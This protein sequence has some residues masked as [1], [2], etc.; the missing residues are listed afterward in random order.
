MNFGRLVGGVEW[1]QLAQDR[2]R[3]QAV[4]KAVMKLRVLAPRSASIQNFTFLDRYL[5]LKIS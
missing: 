1:I 4:V 5:T 2:E 3:C